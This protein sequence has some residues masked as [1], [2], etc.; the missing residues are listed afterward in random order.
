MMIRIR[1]MCVW[2]MS[3]KR[4]KYKFRVDTVVPVDEGDAELGGCDDAAVRVDPAEVA[5]ADVVDV[6]RDAGVGADPVV[7]HQPN[8]LGLG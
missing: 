4:W 8:E 1:A 2:M 5:R 7:L 3:N 6:H